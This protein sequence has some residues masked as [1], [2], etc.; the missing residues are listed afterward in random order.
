ML[1]TFFTIGYL[2]FPSFRTIFSFLCASG[3]AGVYR[4]RHKLTAYVDESQKQ[5]PTQNRRSG[6]GTVVR[7]LASH[8]C[9]PGSI[10][11][12]SVI[13]GLSLLLISPLLLGFFLTGPPVF[14]PSSK[15][16]M[17]KFQFDL[18]SEGHRFVSGET[19]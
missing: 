2:G 1:L 4:R 18:E 8:Q 9:G 11:G 10:P 16:N 7:A 15:A 19:V 13:C 14:P 12:S 5:S 3:I 6:D 17:S